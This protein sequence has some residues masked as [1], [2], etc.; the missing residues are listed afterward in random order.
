[1]EKTKPSYV[2]PTLVEFRFTTASFD[3]WM[4]KVNHDIF[5]LA[6]NFLKDNW[7]SKHILNQ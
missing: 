3:M 2:L 6:I 4:S 5:T 7:Q 1:M